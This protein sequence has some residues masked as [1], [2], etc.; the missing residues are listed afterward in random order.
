[1]A[2][3]RGVETRV[4]CENL[5]SQ[6]GRLLWGE[7]TEKAVNEIGDKV[8]RILNFKMKIFILFW[9]QRIAIKKYWGWYWQ[10]VDNSLLKKKLLALPWRIDWKV[11]G[12]I[13]Q[14]EQRKD[15]SNYVILWQWGLD[16]V[17]NSDIRMWEQTLDTSDVRVRW[18]MVMDVY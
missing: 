17:G 9:N 16:K 12:P 1:M 6:N 11:E 7:V 2:W 3:V 15:L 8:V 5:N 18:C 13:W 4:M 10:Y 14:K